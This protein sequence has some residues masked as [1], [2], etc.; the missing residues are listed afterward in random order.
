MSW[1]LIQKPTDAT[2]TAISTQGRQTYD[3]ATVSYDDPLVFYD[4]VDMD[5]W[6][7]IP[8]PSNGTTVG[9]GMTMGLIIP[10]TRPTGTTPTEPWTYIPKPS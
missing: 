4:S 8:K 10:L 2:W 1:T 7:E 5:A 3:E 9:G 6:M